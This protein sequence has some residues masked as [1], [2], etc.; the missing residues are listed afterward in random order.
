MCPK[1]GKSMFRTPRPCFFSSTEWLLTK[2]TH[3]FEPFVESPLTSFWSRVAGKTTCLCKPTYRPIPLSSSWIYRVAD[4]IVISLHI[5]QDCLWE[6]MCCLQLRWE[7]V[8]T[9]NQ[10]NNTHTD[11]RANP[12]R[13]LF[14]DVQSVSSFVFPY[15]HAPCNATPIIVPWPVFS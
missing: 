11:N 7:L 2:M 12:S 13:Q 10:S 6:Y 8:F 15:H 5:H 4:M 9:L 1:I 14:E 3:I